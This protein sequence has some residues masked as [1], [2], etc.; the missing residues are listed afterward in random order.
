MSLKSKLLKLRGLGIKSVQ[1]PGD[2]HNGRSITAVMLNL[3]CRQ[4]ERIAADPNATVGIK[5]LSALNQTEMRFLQKVIVIAGASAQL[6]TGGQIGQTQV[7]Q[8]TFI[9]CGERR[10]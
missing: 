9:P 3:T 2:V 5:A 4:S 6:T 10:R 1:P 8:N 7:G